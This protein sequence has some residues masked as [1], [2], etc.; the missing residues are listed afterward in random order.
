MSSSLYN[1][2][3]FRELILL[4][5]NYEPEWLYIQP[6]VLTNLIFYYQ[7]FNIVPPKSIRYIETVG[8][9]LSEST[10]KKSSN[11]FNSIVANMYGS[12]E[13]NCIAYECPNNNMHILCDNVFVECLKQDNTI[14]S[15]G[16]GDAIIT[17]L[18]N[19]AMPL[20]RYYQGDGITLGVTKEC[21]CEQMGNI[22]SNIEG[23]IRNK[24]INRDTIITPFMLVRAIDFVNNRF[25]EPII[26]YKFDYYFEKK[27]LVCSL[28]VESDY[29]GW[30]TA[31]KTAVIEQLKQ[32]GF[33]ILTINISLVDKAI[34]NKML[35]DEILTIYT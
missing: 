11:F 27:H 34:F 33:D 25:N 20:I 32:Y 28:W 16:S 24:I 9:I 4:I 6:S 7:Y 15:V 3:T 17:N 8:E 12:E 29:L 26:K 10:R 31:I 13:M 30:S 23:R 1:S 14:E 21:F 2:E 5:Q 18:N 19:K 22:V 35:K